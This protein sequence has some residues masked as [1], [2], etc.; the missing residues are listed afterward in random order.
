MNETFDISTS[1]IGGKDSLGIH[2]ESDKDG[3]V[4][5][6][7]DVAGKQALISREFCQAFAEM[8]DKLEKDTT[9]TGVVVISEDSGFCS[10][11]DNDL[12]RNMAFGDG[13]GFFLVSEYL[14]TCLR[15]IEQLQV[16]VV[17]AINGRASGIGVE[18]CLACNYRIARNAALVV[19][20]MPQVGLGLLPGVGGVI[21]SARLLGPEKALSWL[22]DN[23]SLS[24]EDALA[25]GL[26]DQL[27]DETDDLAAE[28]K[29]FIKQH[30]L[31]W[32]QRWDKDPSAGDASVQVVAG[33][34]SESTDELLRSSQWENRVK[35]SD[36]LSLAKKEVINLVVHGSEQSFDHA[37]LE[38]S[39]ALSKLITT[40]DAKNIIAAKVIQLESIKAG[41]SRP[42]GIAARRFNKIGVIGAGVMGRGITFCA[43]AA[44]IDVVWLG[45][46][47]ESVEKGVSYV[48]ALCDKQVKRGQMTAIDQAKMMALINTTTEYSSLAT[49]E[50]VI[51]AVYE[52]IDVKTR[53]IEQVQPYL[54][55]GVVFGSNTSTLP[56]TELAE[57]SATPENVIGIHFFSPVNR[58]P[59]VEIIRGENTSDKSLAAAFDLSRQLG[60]I[61]IVVK[62]SVGFF[63]SRVYSSYMDEGAR[64]LKEGVDPLMIDLL[65]EEAGMAVG[66]LAIMDEVSQ[67]LLCQIADTHRQLGIFGRGGDTA[68]STEVVE[69]LVNKYGRRG[70]RK[71]GGFYD[72]TEG[73]SKAIWPQ[74]R[75]L[76]LS[77]ESQMPRTDIQDRLIV[78]QVIESL[79]CL[80]E[81]VLSSVADGN[82]G[83]LLGIAAPEW[84]GG[85]LQMINTWESP[86]NTGLEA[87][88]RR[89]EA[90]VSAYGE[91]FKA[92]KILQS[93]IK[94]GKAFE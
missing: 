86:D 52:T 45:R 74:L 7:L 55:D 27:I 24:A 88:F 44:G 30:P 69:L 15:R 92:P 5:V 61:P 54:G 6:S 28:A 70:R 82:I 3:I 9:L 76:Y 93:R 60:K 32:V 42:S 11:M 83:S 31:D 8:L 48:T 68:I 58:M 90:L 59:L 12:W 73:G 71:G 41:V 19:F 36:D 40:K 33:G 63:T 4:T 47:M 53:V 78:R 62:D 80:E 35:H 43:V 51:E 1:T 16:P 81:G 2:W 23:R 25:L 38:E 91:R 14:K 37:C 26:I 67:E 17:A 65:A 57:A 56:I 75:T 18:I 72:Y 87:F 66:P 13:E 77:E 10:S 64:L 39:R 22:L 79:R 94:S 85:Y 89:A 49:C 20:D 29:A 84:S 46:S 50:L 34:E 21:R